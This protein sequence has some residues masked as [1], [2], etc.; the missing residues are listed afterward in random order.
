MRIVGRFAWPREGEL[1]AALIGPA[2]EH[3]RDKLRAIVNLNA[4]GQATRCADGGE[5]CHD[6]CP[7]NPLIDPNSETFTREEVDQR[8]C[9]KLPTVVELIAHEIHP[10]A[11]VQCLNYWPRHAVRC[12]SVPPRPALEER[13]SF[14]LVQAVHALAVN[15]PSL[16]TQHDVNALV[17]VAHARGGDLLDA[18]AQWRLI[19]RHRAIVVQRTRNHHGT[20]RLGD[21]RAVLHP[22]VIDQ[23]AFARGPQAF[24]LS[25]SCNIALSSERSATRR[26]SFAFSSSSCFSRRSSEGP[27]PEYFFFHV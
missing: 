6:V 10:P 24:R 20:A 16:P 9:T 23:L 11:L 25:T 27:S 21:A 3:L 26:F 19:G 15:H 5:R 18:Q 12:R 2:I 13:Q 7:A 22:Q 1:H 17:A 14:L 4:T 8:Q